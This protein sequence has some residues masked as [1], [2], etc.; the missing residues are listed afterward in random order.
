MFYTFGYKVLIFSDLGS[1]LKGACAMKRC[2]RRFTSYLLLAS[3]CSSILIGAAI[4]RARPVLAS[5]PYVVNVVLSLTGQGAFLGKQEQQSLQLLQQLVNKNNGIGGRPIQFNVADDQTNPQVDVQLFN[6]FIARKAVAVIGPTM[7]APCLAAGA[8]I[9]ANGP[10]MYCLS[11]VVHTTRGAYLFSAG[12]TLNDAIT[13]MIRNF[14]LHGTK[15]LGLITSNDATGQDVERAVAQTL[16]LPE[17]STVK[18]VESSRFG[19]TD[20]SVAAQMSRL[21]AANTDAIIAWTTGT[22]WGTL[23]HGLSDAGIDVPI[24][25]SS[26]NMTDAQMQQ[27]R[28]ILPHKLYFAAP[29]AVVPNSVGAGPVRDAQKVYFSAYASIGQHP[30]NGDL[31]AWDPAMVLVDALRHIGP[32]ATAQQ[33]R[34]Y[35]DNL[36][37]WAGTQ[38]M[39]DFG[40]R[41]QRGVGESS[42]VIIGWDQAKSD[43]T[44]ESRP[45]GLLKQ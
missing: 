41:E 27:Y 10:V 40:D 7:T 38:G 20:I 24:G 33:I 19:L 42:L 15:R 39:Y 43:W 35:I 22:P 31:L 32:A 1:P 6:D 12:T 28:S 34:E 37:G 45:G 5:D 18:L 44:V 9:A 21:K 29:S 36:H 17:N 11:P 25:A 26:G 30:G 8:L 4:A 23:L 14:R 13:V 3:M 2:R 16:S